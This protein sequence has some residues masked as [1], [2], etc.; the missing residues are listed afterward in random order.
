MV[1]FDNFSQEN[2]NKVRKVLDIIRNA[3]EF[4]GNELKPSIQIPYKVFENEGIQR[5][6]VISIAKKLGMRVLNDILS[7][8]VSELPN[9]A[10]TFGLEKHKR[11]IT[12]CLIVSIYD[13]TALIKINEQVGNIKDE[14][15]QSIDGKTPQTAIKSQN[16]PL[17]KSVSFDKKKSVLKVN[18]TDVPIGKNTRQHDMLA[19]IFKN[20]KSKNLEWQFG[21]MAEEMADDQ[22]SSN[23][24]SLYDVAN[25]IKTKIIIKT[26]QD[27]VFDITTKTIQVSEDYRD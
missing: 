7:A 25:E 8:Q 5:Y 2:K 27:D 17:K 26:G 19:I 1:D 3:F 24:E 23:W 20:K 21:D 10:T 16:A 6:D 12:D 18:G 4:Q 15:Q 13:K 11:E 9:N 14:Q 22:G